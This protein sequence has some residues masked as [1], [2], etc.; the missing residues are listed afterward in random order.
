MGFTR[1]PA[2]RLKVQLQNIKSCCK[3][4]L[5]KWDCGCSWGCDMCYISYQCKVCNSKY[6][7]EAKNKIELLK[8]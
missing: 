6:S 8:T 3:T 1:F 5:E 4:N 7:L 2:E